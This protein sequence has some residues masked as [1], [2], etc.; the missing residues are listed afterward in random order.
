MKEDKIWRSLEINKD[1][2]YSVYLSNA[3]LVRLTAIPSTEENNSEYR[4]TEG[5]FALMHCDYIHQ[6]AVLIQVQA[7]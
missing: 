7:L 3:T 1:G 2:K 5:T 4:E 6:E